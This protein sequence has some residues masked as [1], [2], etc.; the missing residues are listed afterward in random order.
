M[1]RS[2]LVTA[3]A[4]ITMFVAGTAAAQTAQAPAT[5]QELVQRV[6][7]VWHVEDLGKAM[8]QARAA[9]AVGRASSLLEGR[10]TQE[11]REAAMKSIAAD[12]KKFLEDTTPVVHDNAQKLVPVTVGSLLAERFNEEE[13]RQ[14]VAMLE[15]PVKRKFE[16]LVPEMQK[17]LGEKLA[18]ESGPTVN[19]KLRELSERINDHL[20]VAV[21]P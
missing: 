14:L 11:K 12:T 10:T 7:Q 16:E 13:L 3:V 5:K 4:A 8:L 21:M 18:A 17:S 15:S 6:L 19:A 9:E 1:F 20:R 2:T